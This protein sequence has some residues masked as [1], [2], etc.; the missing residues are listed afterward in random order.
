MRRFSAAT[1]QYRI[2]HSK[3]RV[4]QLL[5]F[6]PELDS[7]NTQMNPPAIAEM[8]RCVTVEVY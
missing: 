3:L 4:R 2:P 5:P 1:D 6:T 7:C 8:G